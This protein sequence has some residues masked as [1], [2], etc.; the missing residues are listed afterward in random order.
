[1]VKGVQMIR[2]ILAMSA[3][4]FASQIASAEP[5]ELTEKMTPEYYN[6]EYLPHRLA[7]EKWDAKKQYVAASDEYRLASDATSFAAIRAAMQRN[8]AYELLKYA[9]TGI[10]L[11]KATATLKTSKS[12]YEEALALLDEAD[13]LGTYEVSRARTRED[14][15]KGLYWIGV[16]QRN[17]EKLLTARSDL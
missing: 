4:V 8:S 10:G 1:M 7:A 3:F 9:Q 15:G 16:L 6:T 11:S 13:K 14:I 5:V 12:L 2:M 17:P